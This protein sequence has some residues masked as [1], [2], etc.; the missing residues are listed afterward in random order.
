MSFPRIWPRARPLETVVVAACLA[1]AAGA[2]PAT[3]RAAERPRPPN[4]ILVLMDDMG[5]RD[6]GFMGNAFVET[7][8]LDRLARRGLVFTQSYAS[9]P[10]CAPTRACLMSGQYTPRHGVYTVVDPRQPPGSP[11]PRLVAADSR[12]ELSTGGG[13]RRADPAYAA[14]IEAVDANV[15][16]IVA[17]LGTGARPRPGARPHAPRLAGGHRRGDP[18]RGEP[19]LRSAGRPTPRRAAGWPAGRAGGRQRRRSRRAEGRPEGRTEWWQEGRPRGPQGERPR[20][21]A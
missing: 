11:W 16:R 14:T 3:A 1:F 19:R 13:D 9:A 10:N 17:A 21:T 15:G 5:W 4:V 8:H 18:A 7:P 12:A 20:G 2:M 6:V